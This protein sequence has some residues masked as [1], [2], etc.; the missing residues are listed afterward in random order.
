MNCMSKT[1]QWKGYKLH[2][3]VNEYNIPIASIITSA[4]V[5]DSLCGIPLVRITEERIDTLYYLADKGYDSAA[6][7]QE[8]Q[9]FNK[10]PLIDFKRRRNGETGGEF[11]GNQVDRYKKRT[12][13]ESVFSQLKMNYLPRYI[14]YRGTEKVRSVLNM[15]LAVITAVQ[16]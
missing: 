5:H 4:S 11:I 10:V 9:S 1:H 15:A 6:I 3:M 13:V 16:I 14:L 2:T 12:F 8:V 7:R